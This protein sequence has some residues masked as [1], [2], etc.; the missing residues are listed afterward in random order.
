MKSMAKPM[1]KS[2]WMTTSIVIAI[3]ST[4]SFS[5]NAKT[6]ITPKIVGGQNAIQS[7][8]PY[9]VSLR[10]GSFG[11]F[12]G[13]SLIA[14]NWVLTAAHCVE[15]GSVDEVWIGMLDQKNTDGVEKIKPTKIIAH[16]KYN[17]STMDSDFALIQLSQNSS[18]KPVALNEVEITVSEDA[19]AAQIMAITAGWGTLNE[20]SQTLPDVLQKVT[21]PLV[22][23][24]ACNDKSAYG[25]DIT[26]TMLC[27]GFKSGGKDSCQGDSGGPLV[28]TN[29]TGETVLAGVVSWGQGCA[30]AN[31]YGI[32][33]KVSAG[34]SWIKENMK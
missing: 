27:A 26:D 6:V 29:A 11:H 31:K 28:V 1:I 34:L 10:S 13:G 5:A 33:S 21:V 15:G 12:C 8:F 17:S 2:I 20:G 30:R 23:Q 16:E 9:I 19:A 14:A 32:Y 4:L 25:G 18:Y 22:S 24:T 7:E 3:V